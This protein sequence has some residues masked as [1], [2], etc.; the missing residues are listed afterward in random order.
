M[1]RTLL[2]G[3]VSCQLIADQCYE[4]KQSVAECGMS[5]C[6]RTL[7]VFVVLVRVIKLTKQTFTMT[8]EMQLWLNRRQHIPKTRKKVL[9]NI[10]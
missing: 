4:R 8:S 2:L 10:F 7:S 3:G 1:S 6:A 9:H 5:D